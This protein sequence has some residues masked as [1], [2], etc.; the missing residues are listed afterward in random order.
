MLLL[1]IIAGGLGLTAGAVALYARKGAPLHRRSGMLFVYTMLLMS[2]SGALIAALNG[3]RISVV[4]GLLTFYLVSTALLTVRRP[5][6]GFPWVDVAASLVGLT[7]ALLGISVGIEG[8]NSPSGEVDGLPGVM[9]SIFGTVALLAL[10]GDLRLLLARGVQGKQR[11]VRH[12]WRMCLALWIATASF[13]LGQADEFPASLRNPAFLATPVVLVLLLLI[14][15]TVRVRF[16]SWQ[17]R[18]S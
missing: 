16:L 6:W 1:H 5:G 14:Y 18:T 12:L 15:W 7:A 3:G 2:A 17:P 13:F 10:I 9:G 4:A 8:L 11:L